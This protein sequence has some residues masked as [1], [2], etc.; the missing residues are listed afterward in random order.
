LNAHVGTLLLIFFNLIIL[1]FSKL[2]DPLWISPKQICIPTIFVTLYFV[3][4]SM[5]YFTKSLD[6]IF[7]DYTDILV[8]FGIIL[9]ICILLYRYSMFYGIFLSPLFQYLILFFFA[10]GVSYIALH[11]FSLQVDPDS[12]RYVISTIVQSEAAILALVFSLSLVIMQQNAS[13]Y[14][15][16]TSKLFHSFKDNPIFYY[17][18]FIYLISIILGV[19][20]LIQIGSGLDTTLYVY[21]T[22]LFSIFSLLSMYPFVSNTFNFL[23]PSRLV[24]LLQKNEKSDNPFI[25][26]K[27]CIRILGILLNSL[28]K[29]DFNTVK[30]GLDFFDNYN[31]E[32]LAMQKNI[33][34]PLESNKH[35]KLEKS[36]LCLAQYFVDIGELSLKEGYIDCNK[37]I[38]KNLYDINKVAK[39]HNIQS[40]IPLTT[41]SIA[42]LG[43]N[44]T[45]PLIAE[46]NDMNSEIHECVVFAL[47][48]VKDDNALP[49]IIKIFESGDESVKYTVISTLGKI[50]SEEAISF[51]LNEVK[52]GDRHM[53]NKIFSTFCENKLF[54][55][56]F[57]YEKLKDKNCYLKGLA[58][59]GLGEIGDEQD[60]ETL[61]NLLRE[62][63]SYVREKAA[64][65]LGIIN[66]K[67]TLNNY[68]INML[69]KRTGDSDPYVKANAVY[70]LRNIK[71]VD[72]QIISNIKELLRH[73]DPHVRNRTVDSLR[74]GN[75]SCSFELL[76]NALKIEPEKYIRL[77]ILLTLGCIKGFYK[78]G[79]SLHTYFPQ[80][81][82]PS[83]N[84]KCRFYLCDIKSYSFLPLYLAAFSP[85]FNRSKL[86]ET[87]VD[88]K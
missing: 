55:K 77:K 40:L 1:E 41:K 50:K 4:G 83:Y 5:S 48:E 78:I 12:A 84:L 69:V 22:F 79:P 38:I 45:Y 39:I 88:L 58:A 11:E 3:V 13:S 24:E 33:V 44:A 37:I 67:Y 17:T 52:K 10:C 75:Y 68:A 8:F 82:L 31:K 25:E 53:I 70:S 21:L 86:N 87:F 42:K 81:S 43:R 66:D 2:H 85:K 49:P 36:L 7:K 59:L 15:P 28:K 74:E 64:E 32:F 80:M 73:S 29:Y 27:N 61:S 57:L 56:E 71:V 54:S 76:N 19:C 47:G 23:I 63:D 30:E 60:I 6:L 72:P 18:L 35:I 51:L 62:E 46:L 16:D 26:D 34:I 20:V 14:P 9:F 65:A